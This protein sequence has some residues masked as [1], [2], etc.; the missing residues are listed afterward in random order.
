M[1]KLRSR[2]TFANVVSVIAVFIAL[3]GTGYAAFKLPK[4]SV[5]TKQLKKNSVTTAK[6]KKKAVTAVKVKDGTLTGKQINL[7]TLGTVPTAQTANTLAPAENWHGVGLENGWNIPSPSFFESPG[8]YKDQGG[9]VHLK[10]VVV[11]GS[12]S[13]PI[14]H[15]PAGYRPASGKVITALGLCAGCTGSAAVLFIVGPNIATPEDGAVIP[16]GA[17]T[18]IGLDGITFRAE[19]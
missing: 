16:V 18:S 19:S 11:N 7:S 9:V 13:K 3:G 15:L 6:I 8:F 1:S 10:G 14:F 12:P 2:L 5:G 17:G 4:N